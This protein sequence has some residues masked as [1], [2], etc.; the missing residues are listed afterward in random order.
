[1]GPTIIFAILFAIICTMV[2]S[3]K[4]RNPVGWFFL[5]FFFGIFAVIAVCI[6]SDINA[7]VHKEAELTRENRRLQEQVYQERIKSEQFQHQTEQRLDT[8]DQL[9]N[10]DTRQA[11]SL[12]SDHPQSLPSAPPPMPVLNV[13]PVFETGWYYQKGSTA[14]GPLD[15]N[16][17]LSYLN[18][19]TI[20]FT[21][22]VWHEKIEVW[23]PAEQVDCLR[24]GTA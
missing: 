18:Q 8:H 1:M 22:N 24:G 13:D 10:V 3:S 14:Q 16:T 6:A 4:G 23:K 21:T 20:S 7:R 5:G 11:P 12:G 9:L 15:L 2:A 19:G 17:I